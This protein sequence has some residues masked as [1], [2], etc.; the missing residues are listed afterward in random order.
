LESGVDGFVC[1]D[2]DREELPGEL[3]DGLV[4]EDDGAASN[5]G[6]FNAK[7]ILTRHIV[8]WGNL[9]EMKI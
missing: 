1:T 6:S 3:E 8:A 2:R 4:L 7:S 9:K 5:S